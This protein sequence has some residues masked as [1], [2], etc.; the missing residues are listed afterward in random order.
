MIRR[1]LLCGAASLSL[2]MTSC[3]LKTIETD[4]C[5]FECLESSDDCTLFVHKET[6]VVYVMAHFGGTNT[7][8]AGFCSMIKADGTAY[9]IE[10][11]EM[12]KNN[13]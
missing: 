6:G 2:L 11:Y 1:I 3:D 12:E 9:T 4:N 7:T 5:H 8:Y 10:D 13:E